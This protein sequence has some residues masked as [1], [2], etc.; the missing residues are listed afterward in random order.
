M[1]TNKSDCKI[2]QNKAHWNAAYTN[3]S[4]Q[5]LGWFEE[6]STKTID[7]ITK[8][9]LKSTASILNI[10]VGSSLLI[11]E[12]LAEG[13]T[14]LKA[15]DVSEKAL[16]ILKERL[17]ETASK[18]TFITDNLL[19][20]KKLQNLAPVDLWNDRA[21][22]HFFLEEAEQ[23]AYFNLL[24]QIVADNGFVIIAVFALDGAEK[25]SG[26]PLKR[27]NTEMLQEKLGA[28]FSLITA[29]NYTFIN[30][31]GGERPYIY[32]LFQRKK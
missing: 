5:E 3:K 13:Y 18:V 22:L 30:P 28:E 11:D 25:C 17:G 8:T 14:N 27:Y 7:L 4:T 31:N 26:L 9:G 23:T 20:P 15:N 16:N 32:T 19:A 24:K 21:V 6:K 2:S 10:G 29:F 12:L 1:T